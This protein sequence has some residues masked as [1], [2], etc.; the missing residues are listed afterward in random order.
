MEQFVGRYGCLFSPLEELDAFRDLTDALRRPGVYSAYGPDDAQR[1]HLIAA[2]V[3]KLNRPALVIVPNEMAALRM[4]EDLNLLLDGRVRSLPA[5]E[6]TFLK[7]AASSHG[8]TL[9]RMEALGDCATGKAAALVLSADAMMNRLMPAERLR[10]HVVEID[11][12]MRMEPAELMEKLTDAGY[13]RVQ[14]VEARGQCA[15]RGG[16]LDVYPVGE[17]N[18]LRIEFFDDEINSIRSFDVMTQRSVSPRPSARLYPATETLLKEE[19]R[20]LAAGRLSFQLRN[21][22]SGRGRS[23]QKQLESQFDLTPF[24]DFLRQTAADEEAGASGRSARSAMERNFAFAVDALQTGRSFDGEDSLAPVLLDYE[25]TA[26]DY[27]DDPIV[28]LD[29]P[30]RLRE[31]CENAYLEFKEQFQAALER[32][33]A[34]PMQAELLWHWDTVLSKLDGRSLLIANPFLRTERD[35]APK[36]LFKFECRNA[37]GYQTNLRELA[38][39][40][41]RWKADGWRV[42]LLAGG[43]ARGERLEKALADLEAPAK[44][45]EEAPDALEPGQPVILPVTLNRGFLYPDIRFAILSESDVYGV[46]RQ[47]SRARARSGEKISAFTDLRVGDY[48]VHENHGIGQYMG[49]VRLASDGTYRDFL[50][51]RY[52]GS[53]KLYVPTDQLDRVQKYIGSEG[54]APKLNRLSGGEWQRQKAKRQA[55]HPGHGGRA[56]QALRSAR[57]RARPRLRSGHALAAGV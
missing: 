25:A 3:R 26:A 33:E 5:R 19:E 46:N 20:L 32:E 15:L 24:E 53:D 42:A 29:Q 23:R 40:L 18:A 37:T 43:N 38:A 9:R 27:L 1:A 49:T 30:E 45:M 11:D 8:M 28:V 13:E 6:L 34:L 4:T 22:A 16:I 2:A 44:F 14:L 36:A 41:N 10:G 54:E 31:R 51:I 50:H 17:P 48:V 35:F 47:K 56:A 7:A 21:S 39:D 12:T 55:V 57:I 52:Q